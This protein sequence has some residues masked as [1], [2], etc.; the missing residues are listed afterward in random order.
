MYVYLFQIF[1]CFRKVTQNIILNL[2]KR[3]INCSKSV[4]CP[5]T[6]LNFRTNV[7]DKLIQRANFRI[8]E[9]QIYNYFS[10][11]KNIYFCSMHKILITKNERVFT[12]Q[13]NWMRC[14][15]EIIFRINKYLP[16]TRIQLFI[17]NISMHYMKVMD[18][19]ISF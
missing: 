17:N 15:C 14:V 10:K 16:A 2:Y 7:C 13:C 5:C 4:I 6:L 11:T 19:L 18:D 9:S 8:I 12:M 1:L 3:E